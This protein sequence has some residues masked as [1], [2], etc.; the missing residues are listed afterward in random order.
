MDW[1]DNTGAVTPLTSFSELDVAPG[2]VWGGLASD[3]SATA[4]NV[5][6]DGPNYYRIFQA[7]PRPGT[8][9]LLSTYTIPAAGN[10][11]TDLFLNAKTSSSTITVNLDGGPMP[12]ATTLDFQI[13]VAS[14][15]YTGATGPFEY[16]PSVPAYAAPTTVSVSVPAGATTVTIPIPTILPGGKVTITPPGALPTGWVFDNSVPSTNEQFAPLNLSTDY[17]NNKQTKYVLADPAA[18]SNPTTTKNQ[19]DFVFTYKVTPPPPPPPPHP[20]PPPPPPPP[21]APT[22]PQPVPGLE[23]AGLGV[24]TA[25]MAGAAALVRRRR[26][27]KAAETRDPR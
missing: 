11:I 26:A 19:V 8:N 4:G 10:A 13:Q 14:Q 16:T 1:V 3:D 7:A 6:A 27:N 18:V 25:F 24:L 22:A 12:T 15:T 21:P 23:A 2:Y 17:M 9:A 5:I 20:P